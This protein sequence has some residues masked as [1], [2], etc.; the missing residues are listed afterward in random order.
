MWGKY[1]QLLLN[2]TCA[3]AIAA[4]AAAV[5]PI[6]NPPKKLALPPLAMQQEE[7]IRRKV[8]MHTNH[9]V[10]DGTIEDLLERSGCD[11]KIMLVDENAHEYGPLAPVTE[12][13]RSW[14]L[15]N[16]GTC[17]IENS[18]LVYIGG[19]RMKGE[20]SDMTSLDLDETKE[21]SVSSTAPFFAGDY[22]S[23]WLIRYIDHEG[24][25]KYL[26]PEL[27]IDVNVDGEIP[28][29]KL[30]VI[31]LDEQMLYA[32]EDGEL[33]FNYFIRSGMYGY[34]TPI[35]PLGDV[36]QIYIKYDK[37][38]MN[39]Y[40]LGEGYEYYIEDVPWTMYFYESYAIHGAPWL[41]G[42]EYLLGSPG[43]HGCINLLPGQAKIVY[44]WAN[45]GDPVLVVDQLSDMLD[46]FPDQ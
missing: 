36:Y 20:S 24:Q 8:S 15:K 14:K 12:F 39:G 1:Y 11:Y 26:Y 41:L 19:Q 17:K 29:D 34:E 37:T 32:F 13:V 42:K 9:S 38:D 22:K 10:D 16:V 33:K 7:G 43:S 44:D 3:L 23:I 35:T 6:F 2:F 25:T 18:Q 46:Y 28:L 30:I 45:V 31:S 4:S 5:S 40:A 21:Y 27:F